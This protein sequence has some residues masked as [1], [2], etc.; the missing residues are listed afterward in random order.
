MLLFVI[1]IAYI[2]DHYN[3]F[4]TEKTLGNT[5]ISLRKDKSNNIVKVL[6]RTKKGITKMEVRLSAV[7]KISSKVLIRDMAFNEERYPNLVLQNL[8]SIDNPDLPNSL[9]KFEKADLFK[10][11]KFGVLLVNEG[12]TRDD[13][14][15]SN[16]KKIYK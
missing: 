16:C 13:E 4:A 9:I 10:T 6:I 15:F 12:Q 7:K 2:L 14:F 3:Y 8:R 1:L 5:V 11:Y